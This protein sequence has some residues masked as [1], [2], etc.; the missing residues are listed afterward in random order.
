MKI[1]VAHTRYVHRGGEDM[2]VDQE[3]ELLREHGHEVELLL[4]DNA[5]MQEL[6]PLQQARETL[7]SAKSASRMAEAI[8]QFRPEVVHFHNTFQAMSFSAVEA[9]Y[10]L[11]LP[12]VMTLHNYRLCCP[13]ALFLRDGKPCELCT[14]KPFKFPAV[15]Y[16][17]YRDSK[18]AS[19][20]AATMLAKN[21]ARY[22]SKV[23]R[24][25]A[26]TEFGK[27]RFVAAGL[28]SKS[29][30]VKPNSCVD[31][32]LPEQKRSGCLV[33]A[34]M[35]PEKGVQVVLEAWQGID[36]IPITVIGDGP[37]FD[38]L[39]TKYNKGN[40]EFLGA[41]PSAVVQ[42]HLKRAQLAILPS[43]C[44]EGCPMFLIESLAAGTPI[45][46]SNHGPMPEMAGDAGYT[47]TPGDPKDLESQVCRVMADPDELASKEPIARK[48]YED[49]FT[50]KAN[51][52][53]LMS[54]YE[55][56]IADR[57]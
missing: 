8:G 49:R 6:S 55:Q 1:L 33:V 26:L 21:R 7:W 16:A 38:E 34:R 35:T 53:M 27:S 13:N 30:V 9:A 28:P 39:T 51:Y 20:V 36:D 46:V 12:T 45:L 32:A 40:I 24:Y 4:Y 5:S 14:S 11:G 47:F 42:D 41:Q 50:P 29:L 17:C 37:L 25:I 52:E 48:I 23:S 43:I 54:I 56:A 22:R 57:G 3:V 44:Y 2:V 31:A 10:D 19:L 18:A 15:K